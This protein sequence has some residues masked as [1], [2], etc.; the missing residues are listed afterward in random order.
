MR[1]KLL[2]SINGGWH[3]QAYSHAHVGR[4]LH[5]HR[6]AAHAT[7]RSLWHGFDHHS[8]GKNIR[9]VRFSGRTPSSCVRLKPKRTLRKTS[10]DAPSNC[11]RSLIFKSLTLTSL[12]KSL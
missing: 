5:G 8:R 12:Q 9:R 4:Q 2:P 10:T 3:G 6:I 7:H 1:W 11:V